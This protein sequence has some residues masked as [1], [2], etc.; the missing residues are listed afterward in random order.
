MLYPLKFKPILKSQIW[1]GDRLVKAGKKLPKNI[2]AGEPVGESWEISGIDGSVSVV[3]NGFLK[4]N[5]L[6]ELI[7]VYM[8]EI[9]G[10]KTYDTYGLEFPILIK[11]IDARDVLS[12]QVHPDDELAEERHGSR[13]KTEMW[14]VMDCEPGAYIYVGF[15]RPISREEYI[16]A[17]TTGT[18]T[19]L[20]MRYEVQKGEA[21]YIPAGTVHAIGGGLLIAEIQETSDITYR[22]SDWGRLG[23]DGKPRSLHTAE[24]VDA[25]DFDEKN[26]YRRTIN[27]QPNTLHEL[28]SSP[29]FTTNLINVDGQMKRDYSDIDSFVAYVCTEGSLEISTSGGRETLSALE[30]LLLPAET[31]YAVLN[32]KGTVLEVYIK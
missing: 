8:G 4:S 14:Y 16:E 23:A 1:G 26:D 24:A 12:V 3:S 28:V 7:E 19:E 30:S 20:L 15:K 32:G 2:K 27:P 17:V 10:E 11:F 18:M 6:E 21:Y 31:E 5:N 25:I 13:G 9:V 22:I 29:F